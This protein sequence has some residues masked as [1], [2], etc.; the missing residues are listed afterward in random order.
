MGRV[1]SIL[2]KVTD[3]LL[4]NVIKGESIFRFECK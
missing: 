4:A 1:S 2:F 3:L